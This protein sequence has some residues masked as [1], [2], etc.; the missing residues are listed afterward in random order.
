MPYRFFNAT[1]A[2]KNTVDGTV[3]LDEMTP[4]LLNLYA[5]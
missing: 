2:L 5:A 4:L 1:L 3:F